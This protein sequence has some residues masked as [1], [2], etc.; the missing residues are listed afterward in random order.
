MNAKT[1]ILKYG[2]TAA[3]AGLITWTTLELHGFAYLT[4]DAERYRLLADAFTIPGVSLIMVWLLV[5]VSGEGIFDGI[6]YAL[7]Y[8]VTTLLPGMG[9]KKAEAYADYI[10]RK[11]AARAGRMSCA[12]LWH[13]GAAFMIPAAVFIVL[14]YGVY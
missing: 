7:S 5:L 2:I 8:T 6:G 3:A 9:N 1:T 13:V 14:F 11:Q 4:S 12:F 10:E